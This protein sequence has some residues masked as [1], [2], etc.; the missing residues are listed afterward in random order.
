MKKLLT[1]CISGLVAA[2]LLAGCSEDKKSGDDGY[3][4]V[5][6]DCQVTA[7]APAGPDGIENGFKTN[8][9][10]TGDATNDAVIN[11]FTEYWRRY[12]LALESLDLK[13]SC[14]KVYIAARKDNLDKL[15][16]DMKKQDHRYVGYATL[17]SVENVAV[18]NDRAT[19][20][21]CI[22]Q[23]NLMRVDSDSEPVEA[24]LGEVSVSVSLVK[25]DG[26]WRIAKQRA[27]LGC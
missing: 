16:D 18:N 14:A 3:E 9:A 15:V 23:G 27:K 26:I 17:L 4:V 11:D 13:N 19:L 1:L 6:K 10:A 21:A 5:S 22:D 24:P 2:T 8:V 12:I 20:S 25:L 7:T